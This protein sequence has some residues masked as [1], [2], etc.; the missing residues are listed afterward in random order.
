MEPYDDPDWACFQPFLTAL[1]ARDEYA[2]AAA[3][4]I[5]ATGR[6]VHFFQPFWALLCNLEPVATFDSAG[7]IHTERGATELMQAYDYIGRKLALTMAR[8]LGP[9]LP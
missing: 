3:A 8:V 7:V 5:A 6:G 2:R 4:Q 9:Y 1:A